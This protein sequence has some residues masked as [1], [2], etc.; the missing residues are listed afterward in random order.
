M[1]AN[2]TSL[3]L[4]LRLLPSFRRR[5]SKPAP[6]SVIVSFPPKTALTLTAKTVSGKVINQL[7]QGNQCFLDVETVSGNI[8]V[9]ALE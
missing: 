8:S 1:G 3:L 7:A 4:P 9:L 5:R 2:V 6:R